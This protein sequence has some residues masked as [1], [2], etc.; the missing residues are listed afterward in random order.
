MTQAHSQSRDP[1]GL[2]C[3]HFVS[4]ITRGWVH[5]LPNFIYLPAQEWGVAVCERRTLL[6][7]NCGRREV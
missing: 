7:C 6:A 3:P 5:I 4:A 1:L 2:E